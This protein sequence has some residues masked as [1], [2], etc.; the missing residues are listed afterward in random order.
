MRSCVALMP[1]F[2]ADCATRIRGDRKKTPQQ[3]R[4]TC[5]SLCQLL[6]MESSARSARPATAAKASPERRASLP[7]VMVEAKAG[8]MVRNTASPS[9][10]SWRR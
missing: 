7:S 4:P 9:Q 5:T 8:V 6:G 10:A 3:S 1:M 2:E